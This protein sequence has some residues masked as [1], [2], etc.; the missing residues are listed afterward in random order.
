MA[1]SIRDVANHAGVSIATVSRVLNNTDYPVSDAVR[2]QV[3]KSAQELEY[4]PNHSARNLRKREGNGLALIVRNIGDPYYLPIVRG[5]L[6]GH[7]PIHT[8]S[9]LADAVADSK[10]IL[11]MTTADGHK[12]VAERLQGLLQPGQRII[13]FNCNWGAYEFDQVLHD[14]LREKQILVGETGGMLLLSNL[15]RTGE[16][17]LRSIKK[18]MS[19]AAIPA[20]ESERL[21]AELRPVFPQFQPAASVFETSLNATNPILHAPLDLFSLARIDKGESY[22]LYAD[23]ATPVSVGYIE[24]IDAERMAVIRAMGIHGQ[25][26]LEIV[27]DAWSASYTDLL[28]GLLDVKAY[29]TSMGPPSTHYRHFTED[30]PYGICPI[31]KLGRRYGVPTPYTDA[32]LT[33]YALALDLDLAASAPDFSTL[34]PAELL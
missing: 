27:N 24:K 31:Q 25:N 32:I 22:Y 19:L 15:S 28:E 18:K 20:A 1:V 14:E 8:E 34:D 5:A 17:F 3:L 26:C 4:V 2:H 7:F 16:C 6:E 21:A 13:V 9:S 11:V 30:L 23:G 29:K 33:I 12:P 10:Y